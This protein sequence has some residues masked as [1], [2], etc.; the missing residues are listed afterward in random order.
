MAEVEERKR[1]GPS[2]GADTG[3]GT[4]V[5][6]NKSR[7][8]N[9]KEVAIE[10]IRK[11]MKGPAVKDSPKSKSKKVKVSQAPTKAAPRIKGKSYKSSLDRNVVEKEATPDVLMK[12]YV[13]DTKPGGRSKRGELARI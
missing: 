9:M 11:Q 4:D 6:Q 12:K 1:K 3:T 13:R 8:L 10:K 2:G 5:N 7:P